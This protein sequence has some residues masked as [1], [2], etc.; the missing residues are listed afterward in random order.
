MFCKMK[1]EAMIGKILLFLGLLV[2]CITLIGLL[3]V[4][5]KDSD[6]N[7]KEMFKRE[8]VQYEDEKEYN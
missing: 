5:I 6:K 4:L 3:C 7:A 2:A 1:G 8:T